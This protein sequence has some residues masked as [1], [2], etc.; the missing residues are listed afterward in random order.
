MLSSKVKFSRDRQT[1]RQTPVKQYAPIY[2]CE[3]IKMFLVLFPRLFLNLKLKSHFIVFNTVFNM[4]L[5]ILWLAMHLSMLF[6]TFSSPVLC[7]IFCQS[8]WQLYHITIIETMDSGVT[9]IRVLIYQFIL[10]G[11][12][13]STFII[14]GVL[15]YKYAIR[16]F[17]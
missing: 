4:I 12:W 5:V 17:F 8:H 6:R 7:T 10:G 11:P 14:M 16:L 13:D 9:E 3:G 1:E 2:R 15:A